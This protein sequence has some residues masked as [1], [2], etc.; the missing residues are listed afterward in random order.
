MFWREVSVAMLL[1]MFKRVEWDVGL[2]PDFTQIFRR[3]R[4]FYD[5][6]A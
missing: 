4:L 3:R 5:P 1:N 6:V 2:A